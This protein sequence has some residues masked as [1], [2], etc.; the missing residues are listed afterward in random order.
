MD[1]NQIIRELTEERKRL[2]KI[3]ESLEKAGLEGLPS[4]KPRGRRGRKSMDP[5]GRQ[6]VSERMKRYW[7]ARRAEKQQAPPPTQAEELAHT[8]GAGGFIV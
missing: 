6:E 2:A 7:A 4:S 1:V 5:A 8:A 3:I